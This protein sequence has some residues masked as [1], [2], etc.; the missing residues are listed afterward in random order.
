MHIVMAKESA[1]PAYPDPI[2]GDAEMVVT[3]QKGIDIER[4]ALAS[5]PMTNMPVIQGTTEMLVTRQTGIMAGEAP[6]QPGV[7]R[8]DRPA[9]ALGAL[10]VSDAPIPADKDAGMPGHPGVVPGKP[11]GN[12]F[13]GPVADVG[14]DLKDVGRA[15]PNTD[16]QGVFMSDKPLPRDHATGVTGIPDAQVFSAEQLEAAKK[17]QHSDRPA[18]QGA[19]VAVHDP[20]E[21]QRQMAQASTD[22]HPLAKRQAPSK[23]AGKTAT[24]KKASAKKG[25]KA[26]AKKAA[27]AAE[28]VVTTE[29]APTIDASGAP[30][31]DVDAE[32]KSEDPQQGS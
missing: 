13:V 10:V 24:G 21:Y 32:A 5:D 19:P 3:R 12:Q 11:D 31:V 6:D 1:A 9:N 8:A 27:P 15:N 30:V 18:P 7:L 16:V 20:V 28:V 23:A 29:T 14:G 22:A 25:A 2:Q 26:S 4:M 17:T